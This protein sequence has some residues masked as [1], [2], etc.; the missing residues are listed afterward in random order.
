MK[1]VDVKIEERKEILKQLVEAEKN[2]LKL[3]N[4]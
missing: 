3:Q 4:L 1:S 2:I